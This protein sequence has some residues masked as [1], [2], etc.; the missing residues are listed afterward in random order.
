MGHLPRY[1]EWTASRLGPFLGRRVMDAGCGLGHFTALLAER[2]EYVL[3]VDEDAEDVGWLR[4]R[5]AG[6]PHVEPLQLDLVAGDLRPV[7]ERNID[8]IVCL[9]VLEHFENDVDTL[10]AWAAQVDC[11]AKLLLKVPACTGLY[12]SID[13]ASGHVRR[14]SPAALRECVVA[15]GWTPLMMSYMNLAGVF[16]YWFKNK[17]RR[18]NTHFSRAFSRRT[19][20]GINAAIP[21]LERL[22]RLTGPPIGLSV[23]LAAEKRR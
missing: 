7:L 23:V 19:L 12:G 21:L 22:D 14:Y 1:Y 16:P 6:Q 15:A 10:R 18:R 4:E 17:L 5:F 9:D 3:A 20:R 11:G 2:A 13:R 8:T